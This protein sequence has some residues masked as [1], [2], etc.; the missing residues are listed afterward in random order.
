MSGDIS[1]EEDSF[2]LDLSVLGAPH[3]ILDIMPYLID[4][5]QPK[6]ESL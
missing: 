3:A 5:D 2:V 4:L 6:P 1:R